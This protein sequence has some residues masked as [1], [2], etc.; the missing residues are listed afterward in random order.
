MPRQYPISNI[1]YPISNI[2]YPISNIQYPIS[3]VLSLNN[4]GIELNNNQIRGEASRASP[5]IISKYK[6]NHNNKI[7]KINNSQ[8][9]VLILAVRAVVSMLA[10]GK[11]PFLLQW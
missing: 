2:Q 3:L 11:Y 6:N 4:W 8:K 10:L 1:Q 5:R 7:I 9:W